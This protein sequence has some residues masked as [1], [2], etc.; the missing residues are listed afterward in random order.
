MYDA[1]NTL[2]TLDSYL[3]DVLIAEVNFVAG[4]KLRTVEELDARYNI[5]QLRAIAE[6]GADYHM[7]SSPKRAYRLQRIAAHLA[8]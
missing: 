1:T 4:S 5:D 6:S 2:N 7:A 8:S 3:A